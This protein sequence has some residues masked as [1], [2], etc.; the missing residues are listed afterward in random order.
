MK[1]RLIWTCL[2]CLTLTVFARLIFDF[3]T[4]EQPSETAL[5]P[6]FGSDSAPSNG[7]PSK[8]EV[9][10]SNSLPNLNERQLQGLKREPSAMQENEFMKA[11]IPFGA[12][13]IESL[14]LDTQN[15]RVRSEIDSAKSPFQSN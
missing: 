9:A 4:A 11:Q 6:T 2:L 14:I 13:T 8:Q 5:T 1:T 15:T 10:A 3:S 7:E 12:K